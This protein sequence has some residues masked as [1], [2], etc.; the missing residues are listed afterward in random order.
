MST[1]TQDTNNTQPV[2]KA[3]NQKRIHFI[4]DYCSQR[5]LSFSEVK[6]A[7]W[8]RGVHNINCVPVQPFS[9]IEAGFALQQLALHDN[10]SKNSLFYLNVAPRKDSLIARDNNDGE[11]LVYAELESGAM[12]IATSS[13]YSLA[14]VKDRIESFREVKV[15][16]EGSQF[17]SRDIFPEAVAAVF[18]CQ[19]S[20]LGEEL[21]KDRIPEPP[22]SR[23]GYIDGFGN[24]KTTVRL[25]EIEADIGD[26]IGIQIGDRELKAE[27][28]D[29]IFGVKDG[30]AV[31]AP[32]SSGGS[33]P[34]M[35][36]VVR[37]GSAE[38]T[39]TNPEIGER[40][41]LEG[42]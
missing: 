18:H 8:D 23:V 1:W 40:I 36:I 15:S 22:N 9:T 29:G 10:V 6:Q 32:G 16:T 21:S 37:G 30:E 26:S 7:L 41:H 12:I 2:Q 20:L 11:P 14:M 25:S 3:E 28:R 31:F 38:E 39:L 4:A 17:R 13:G 24:I 19:D 35:E 27:R 33:D 42:A 5:R 34:F